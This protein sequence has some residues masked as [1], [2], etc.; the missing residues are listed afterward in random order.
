MTTKDNKE[1]NKTKND[2]NN[3]DNKK[4]DSNIIVKFVTCKLTIAT[5]KVATTYNFAIACVH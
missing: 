4:N 3:N 2:D 1:I 5:Y